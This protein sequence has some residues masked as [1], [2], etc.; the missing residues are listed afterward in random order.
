MKLIEKALR[1]RYRFSSASGNLTMED[2]YVIP[3]NSSRANQ[4]CLEDVAQRC[5]A[6]LKEAGETSFTETNKVNEELSDK[7]ELVKHVIA[8]RKAE[9]NAKQEAKAI[10]SHNR[11][12]DELIAKKEDE[13]L[14]GKSIEELQALRK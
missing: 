8:V 6:H 2:L 11:R 3:M 14:Q 1:K 7:M 5:N 12:I 13:S 10:A 9:A 4:A